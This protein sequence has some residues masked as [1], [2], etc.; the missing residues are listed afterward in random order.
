MARTRI[1]GID[2]PLPEGET[3]L[4]EGRPDA[5]ALARHALRIRWI[6][7]YFA[8][9]AALAAVTAGGASSVT[10][11][12]SWILILGVVVALMAVGYAAL[13]ARA[14]VYAI[15]NKRVVMRIG[16]AFP[17]IFNLPFNKVGGAEVRAF[18]DG[19]GEIALQ[20]TGSGRIGYVY[21]WPHV[22][23]LRIA[24]PEPMLRG[25]QPV[26]PVAELLRDALSEAEMGDPSDT[27]EPTPVHFNLLDD[28]GTEVVHN[29]HPLTTSRG[30]AE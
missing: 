1:R 20:V 12:V 9:L 3:L 24:R 30:G 15:T 27:G 17:A 23:P 6:A 11:R 7:G 26:A 19:S 29:R 13:T 5:R 14:T 16:V 4:W 25:L 8:V 2:E 22:R 28:D 18:G 21:L 10:A